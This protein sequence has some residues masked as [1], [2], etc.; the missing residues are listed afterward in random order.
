MA[1]YH[2]KFHGLE[3]EQFTKILNGLMCGTP[4][5]TLAREI[6]QPPPKGWGMMQDVSEKTLAQQLNRLRL[7]A[8]AGAFG[9]EIAQKIVENR[10]PRPQLTLLKNVSVPVLQRLEEVSEAKRVLVLTLLEKATAEK[11]TFTSVNEAVEGY[12][13]LLLDL[14]KLRF[15]LGL[16]EFKGPVGSTTVKGATQTTTFPDGMSVQKQVYEAVTTIEKI[17]DAR[18][19]PQSVSTPD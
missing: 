6:Q 7:D 19:I 18:K 5:Q 9:D 2:Q 8:A 4:A 17:F 16:D 14:Q 15:D 12:R 3:S 10:S 11:R 13:K 1:L